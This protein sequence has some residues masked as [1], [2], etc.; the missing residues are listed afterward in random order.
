MPF[1]FTLV[2][3][4][5]FFSVQASVI[6]NLVSIQ[7][8]VFTSTEHGFWTLL[9]CTQS[10]CIIAIIHTTWL[11]VNAPWLAQAT[12]VCIPLRNRNF[13]NVGGVKKNEASLFVPPLACQPVS[14]V[15]LCH[16]LLM[17][18]F[19][20]FPYFSSCDNTSYSKQIFTHISSRLWPEVCSGISS[21]FSN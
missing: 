13:R 20:L 4:F 6:S 3:V 1:R 9:T 15:M 5:F 12:L 2:A 10:Y 18:Q 19:W 14:M 21:S 7:C 11:L 17:L 8:F 16:Y